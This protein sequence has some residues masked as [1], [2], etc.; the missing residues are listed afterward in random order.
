[1]N[2]RSKP[3]RFASFVLPPDFY[4]EREVDV[5]TW[6]EAVVEPVTLIGA[7]VCFALGLIQLGQALAPDWPTRFLPP[8]A[9]LVG[10]E[11]FFYSRR[12]ARGTVMFKEW[13]VLLVPVIVLVR[14]LPYLDDPA[15]SLPGD[16]AA[17]T[18]SPGS[19]FSLAFLADCLILFIVWSSVFGA[20]QL[21]NSLRIQP[22]EIVEEKD[23]LRQQLYEDNFRAIDH[24][25]PLLRLGQQFIWGGVALVFIAALAALGSEQSFGFGLIGEIVGFQRPSVHLVQLNVVLYFVFGL[26]L[27]GEAHFVRQRTLWRLDHLDVPK[28]LPS[29]WVSGVATLIG[30]AIAVGFVLPTEYAMSLGDLIA[31]VLSALI[32][33]FIWLFAAVLF[34]IYLVISLFGGKGSTPTPASPAAPP[35]HLVVA[36]H[37]AAGPSILDL[38]KS[39]LFWVVLL[40]IVA[41]ALSVLWQR[42]PAWLSHLSLAPI[43]ALPWR[44]L[45]GL[46]GL[47]WRVGRGVSRAVAAVVPRLFRSPPVLAVQPP[48]F[49][50]LSRL[51]PRDLVEYFYLSVCERA[52]RLGYPRPPGITPVEYERYLETRLPL[53]DPEIKALTG[54]FLEARYGPRPTTKE[55]VRS[56]RSGWETLKKKLRLA[57]LRRPS[58]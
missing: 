46:A 21:L 6:I 34:V 53:V 26:G 49:V 37:A 29:R 58:P 44:L 13:L 39:V 55:T 31:L 7:A 11:A 56:V 54:A 25:A 2:E 42:R 43:V 38:L 8:L 16:L 24:L 10:I 35:P 45:Q 32:Q 40:A 57:R 50:N 23:R 48:R 5:T 36:A 14:F 20:V 17:W 12:L 4:P 22:G 3:N 28:E 33:A 27:L 9:I 18:A 41:Y 19:F 47:L 51:G 52:A 15:A 1:M 30:L